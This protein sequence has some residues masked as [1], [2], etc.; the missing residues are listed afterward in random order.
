MVSRHAR[1]PLPLLDA[2][3]GRTPSCARLWK[4]AAEPATFPIFCSANS[5]GR[6]CRWISVRMAC[7]MRASWESTTLC[8]AISRALPFADGAFDMMLSLDVIV[9]SGAGRRAARRHANSRAS[10]QPGGL[11]VVRTSALDMLRSRHVRSSPMSASVSRAAP[12]RRCSPRAGVRVLR[13]TYANSLLMPVALAKFRVWEPLTRHARSQRGA[14]RGA[15][16][17]RIFTCGAGRW[18]PRGSAR[19]HN[20]PMGQSLIL[21]GEKMPEASRVSRRSASSF[22]RTTMRRRCPS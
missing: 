7:T 1:H 21:I 2:V 14:A 5:T 9:P 8:K 18:R 6:S 3:P 12:H 11:V 20:F 15:L 4:P 22:R 17:G 10:S 16:A 19:G 13:C